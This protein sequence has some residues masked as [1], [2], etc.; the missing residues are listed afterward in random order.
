VSNFIKRNINKKMD[1][2]SLYHNCLDDS[3]KRYLAYLLKK[4]KVKASSEL[5]VK[6]WIKIVNVSVRL[7]NKLLCNYTDIDIY[8]SQITKEMFLSH[9]KTGIK[10][11]NEFAE[12]RGDNI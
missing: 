4:E 3:D 9:N 7:R 2:Y 5:L 1:L 6:D 12:L 10:T 11:W 8:P